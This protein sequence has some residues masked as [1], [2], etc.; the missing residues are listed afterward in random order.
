MVPNVTPEERMVLMLEVLSDPE[1]D[2][3]ACQGYNKVGRGMD[4]HGGDD[5]LICR[6]GGTFWNEGTLDNYTSMRPR[7]D[8]E[9]AAAAEEIESGGFTWCRSDV[10][11]LITPC[12]VHAHVDRVFAC[13][14]E[15][16]Y[17][18]DVHALSDDEDDEEGDEVSARVSPYPSDIDDDHVGQDDAAVAGNDG[19][20]DAQRKTIE[21]VPLSALQGDEVQKVEM[22]VAVLEASI[23]N[24]K[25]VGAIKSASPLAKELQK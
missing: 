6:E 18:D 3:K 17:Y 7:I 14:G 22:M 25:L 13:L 9:L 24:L 19:N 5:A 4:L 8:V 21:N 10:T 20:A 23:D 2:R 15:D 16:F 12:K 11:G 1:L